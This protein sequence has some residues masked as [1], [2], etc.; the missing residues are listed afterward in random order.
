[1]ALVLTVQIA[2]DKK[3]IPT[4]RQLIQWVGA[5]LTCHSEQETEIEPLTQEI[6][7]RV[8]DKEESG[9]L[10]TK[11]RRKS[12]PTNVLSFPAGATVGENNYLGDLVVCAPLVYE[13]AIAQQKPLVA[14]WAHLVIHGVLHLLGYDHEQPDEAVIMEALEVTV[15]ASLGY[16]NPYQSDQLHS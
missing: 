1:M 11:F 16:D 2:C 10:N 4:R 5:A 6:T 14:H 12:Y 7:L 13:E 15:L 3:D 9:F 8:V